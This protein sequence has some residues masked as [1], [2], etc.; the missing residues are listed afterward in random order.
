MHLSCHTSVWI[1]LVDVSSPHYIG[2]V[3]LGLDWSHSTPEHETHI[4]R[5]TPFPQPRQRGTVFVRLAQP[6]R[7]IGLQQLSQGEPGRAL[8][9]RLEVFMSRLLL[10]PRRKTLQPA[11]D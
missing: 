10:S 4:L 8:L 3:W 9:P 6:L 5:L 1:G 7:P 2:S 11:A